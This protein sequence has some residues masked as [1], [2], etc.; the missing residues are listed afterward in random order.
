MKIDADDKE[1]VEEIF[2]QMGMTTSGAVN[3][4]I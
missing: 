1:L 3:M 4:F 2:A